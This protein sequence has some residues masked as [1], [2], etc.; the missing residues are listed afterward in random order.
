MQIL[1][2]SE[3]RNFVN[4][5][6]NKVIA[7][8]LNPPTIILEEISRKREPKHQN[9]RDINKIKIIVLLTKFAS[10]FEPVDNVPEAILTSDHSSLG[11]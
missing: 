7:E 3:S 9:E 11:D 4:L 10:A 8:G 6:S 1:S 5:T 2:S